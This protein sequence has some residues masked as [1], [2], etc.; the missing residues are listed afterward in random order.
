MAQ[1]FLLAR[2]RAEEC[3]ADGARGVSGAPRVNGAPGADDAPAWAEERQMT[4][5]RAP[6]TISLDGLTAG[7]RAQCKFAA[8][9]QSLDPDSQ[10]AVAVALTGPRRTYPTA[11]IAVAVSAA[12]ERVSESSVERH[13]SGR[14][15]CGA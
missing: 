11:K 15:C 4:G 10:A 3:H 5:K 7:R 13:R 2:V 8:V 6:V 14:C 9:V 1:G 12:R